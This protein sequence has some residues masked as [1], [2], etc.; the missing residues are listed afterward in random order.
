MSIHVQEV[1][2]A[3]RRIPKAVGIR[4]NRKVMTKQLVNEVPNVDKKRGGTSYEMMRSG[5]NGVM[6]ARRE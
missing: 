1:Q 3:I 5:D 4:Q 2:K 6:A